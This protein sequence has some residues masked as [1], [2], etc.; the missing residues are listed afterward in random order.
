M[1]PIA[2]TV[3]FAPQQCKVR[4]QDTFSSSRKTVLYAFGFGADEDNSNNDDDD[5]GEEEFDVEKFMEERRRKKESGDANVDEEDEGRNLS[6]EFFKNLR[7]R[8]VCRPMYVCINVCVC[9]SNIM[10]AAHVIIIYLYV[11]THKSMYFLCQD[12]TEYSFG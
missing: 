4:N 3:A 6:G 8:N 1:L 11:C 5:N 12:W 2:L 7:I 9:E 10:C